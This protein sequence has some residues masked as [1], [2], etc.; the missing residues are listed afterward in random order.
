MKRIFLI[1]ASLFVVSTF[2]VAQAHPT[3]S[4][5]VTSYDGSKGLLTLELE[6]GQKKLFV[7]DD[8]TEILWM[9]RKTAAGALPANAKVS[10]QVVGA[11]NKSPLK[12]RKIVDWG[13]SET[14][15]AKTAK[16]PYHTPVAQYATAAGG[17]GTPD[18]APVGNHSPQH[19]LAAVGHGGSANTLT[20][21]NHTPGPTGPQPGSQAV[22]SM[23]QSQSSFYSNQGEAMMGPLEMMH[24]DPYS[25]S[26]GPSSPAYPSPTMPA[27]SPGTQ[28]GETG[29]S[30]PFPGMP[31]GEPGM[32]SP[33][34][35]PSMGT[36]TAGSLMGLGSDEDE[37]EGGSMIFSAGMEAYGMAD[38][39]K[40]TGRVLQVSVEQGFFILQSIQHPELQRI[41]LTPGSSNAVHLLVTGQMVEVTGQQS[42]QGFQASSINPAP[43]F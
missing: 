18:G 20:P 4:G 14:I 22:S 43:G 28:F 9:G 12:A 34:Y 29:M 11:L 35:D 33:S 24:I 42:P 7:L 30:S 27:V 5:R 3:M 37:D 38:G 16:A 41:L 1:F 36:G 10:I 8:Q 26:V 31:M 23:G 17:G 21:H 2:L 40:M 25:N 15:V 13:S 19:T 39:N 6:S 32:M